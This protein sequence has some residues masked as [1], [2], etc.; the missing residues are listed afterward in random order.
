LEKL[1][2]DR[3]E[4]DQ[5]S[6]D[7]DLDNK[8]QNLLN[9][10]D[11]FMNDDF[12]TAKVLA[13]MFDLAHVINSIKDKSVPLSAISEKTFSLLRKKFKEYLQDIFGLRDAWGTGNE[14]L[15]GVINL[16]VE[17]RKDARA[18][19]DFATSDKIR[20]QLAQLGILLKDEKDGNI[21]WN[22]S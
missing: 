1:G 22:I 21:S 16:L 11:T 9:E 20:N 14:K 19:K 10:F 2:V 12:N 15:Q 6:I 8:V 4:A 3:Q 13:N 5:T 17:I 18:K 7:R